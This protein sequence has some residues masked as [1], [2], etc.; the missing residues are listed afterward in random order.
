MIQIET[1][2][3]LAILKDFINSS[4]QERNYKLSHSSINGGVYVMDALGEI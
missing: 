2:I 3:R 1:L 4:K